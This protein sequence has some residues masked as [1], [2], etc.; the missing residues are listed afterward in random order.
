MCPAGIVGGGISARSI[1]KCTPQAIHALSEYTNLP[2]SPVLG[3][4]KCFR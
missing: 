3:T 2:L 1:A 4:T